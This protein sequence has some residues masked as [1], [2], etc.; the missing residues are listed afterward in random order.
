VE[1][2]VDFA[3]AGLPLWARALMWCITRTG[4]RTGDGVLDPL[5]RTCEGQLT[6]V[7]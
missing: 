2:T 5:K 1:H 4:E 3:G 7:Q 6:S